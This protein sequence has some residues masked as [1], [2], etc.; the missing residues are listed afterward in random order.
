MGRVAAKHKEI[1]DKHELKFSNIKGYEHL[2]DVDRWSTKPPPEN[3]PQI[4]YFVS[5]NEIWDEERIR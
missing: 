3:S 2:Q 5:W 4:P 1:Q